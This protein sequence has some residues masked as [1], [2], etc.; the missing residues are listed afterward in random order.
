[1]RIT[2]RNF[3]DR[4]RTYLAAKKR[5][6]SGE[7]EMKEL[8]DPIVR[9]VANHGTFPPAG[10]KSLAFATELYRALAAFGE[11]VSLDPDAIE[12]FNR[13]FGRHKRPVE[14]GAIFQA[15]TEYV[16]MPTAPLA[17]NQLPKRLQRM[18]SRI[19]KVKPKAPALTVERLKTKDDD[20]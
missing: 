11:T 7:A 3:D 12:K 20:D 5:K 8:K 14:F 16:A 18:Y 1:M 13:E 6:E 17:V 4:A 2:P 19:R 15:R 10:K 9:F